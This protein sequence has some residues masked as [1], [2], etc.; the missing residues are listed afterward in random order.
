MTDMMSKRV[1]ADKPTTNDGR[2]YHLHTRPGDLAPYC[3]LVGAPERATMI[4]EKLL[5]RAPCVGYHRGLKSFTGTFGGGLPV[6]V[7]TTGMGAPSMGIILPEAVRSGARCF[8]RVGSCSALQPHIALHDSIIVTGAMRLEGASKNWAPP[9]FPAC[10][11]WRVVGALAMVAE[12][13]AE[14]PSMRRPKRV[15]N[16]PFHFHSGIEATTD[17]FNEGQGRPG[18]MLPPRVIIDEADSLPDHL[19]R[20]HNEVMRLARQGAVACYSME[21]SALF[22]WCATHG[23]FWAGAINAVYGNRATNAFGPGGDEDAAYIALKAFLALEDRY[24]LISCT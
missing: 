12:E 20:Q 11:D 14:D 9:E 19:R 23:G 1:Q 4:V 22:V 10:A 3:L 8:I 15:T 21:A 2:E 6:S 18:L 7:V 16:N 17:C 24:P 13:Y 5:L